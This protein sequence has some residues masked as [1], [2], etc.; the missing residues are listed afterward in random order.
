M[1]KPSLIILIVTYNAMPWLEFCLEPLADIPE[2]WEILVVDNASPDGTADELARRYPHVRLVR[3]DENLGFGRANNV[4]LRAA[5]ERGAEH[6]FLLNQDA[7]VEIAAL[8]DL[9]RLQR[10]NPDCLVL[11]PIHLNGQGDELD[12]PFAATCQPE[13]CPGLLHDALGGGL[14]EVYPATRAY[15]AAWM[16]SARTLAV[17]GGFNPYYYHYGEDDDYVNRVRHLGYTVGI[18]PH[19]HV[20]HGRVQKSSTRPMD[21]RFIR[22]LTKALNP[23]DK[24][25]GAAAL[26]ALLVPTIIRNHL[27]GGNRRAVARHFTGVLRDMLQ[28]TAAGRDINEETKREGAAFL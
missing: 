28:K 12:L 23:A 15:A 7:R 17:V 1:S 26:L 21:Y 22:K 9:M 6:V 19:V 24:A 11:S 14:K 20:L 27:R 2:D 18:A 8:W 4:G 5:L 13:P 3:N 25:P 16:L 10:E